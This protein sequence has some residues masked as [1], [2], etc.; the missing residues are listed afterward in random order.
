MLIVVTA[1]CHVCIRPTII[2]ELN[3]TLWQ[4]T[5]LSEVRAQFGIN[6]CELRARCAAANPY[7]TGNV[8]V[9]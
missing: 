9:T 4:E 1:V 6:D 2:T 3:L 5:N 7:R 8:W